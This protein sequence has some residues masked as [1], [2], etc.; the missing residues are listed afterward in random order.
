M[1][2]IVLVCGA[3]GYVGTRLTEFLLKK[4]F[5]VRALSHRVMPPEFEKFWFSEEFRNLER[6]F[7]IGDL[8][9][10]KTAKEMMKG[11]KWV[12]NL[13]ATVGGIGA[14]QRMR[15][16][17]LANATI[18]INLLQ[19]VDNALSGYFFAS[20]SC[21]YPESSKPLVEE[22]ASGVPLVRGY[23][24]EK[25]FSERVCQAF[26]EDYGIP[27][28][29]GRY[30][31]IYGP[32]D[33]RPGREHVT[34]AL[35]RKIVQAKL[36]GPGEVTIWGNGHQTR[37]FLYIDDCVEGTFRLMH[38]DCSQPVNLAHADSASVNQLVD[39]LEDIAGIDVERFYKLDAPVGC[40]NKIAD[41]SRC[42]RVLR[43]EPQVDLRTGLSRMYGD[44]YDA[45]LKTSV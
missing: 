31:T 40:Q 15:A 37:S 13:A 32:G 17:C 45:A 2:D 16:H 42:R 8:R 21:V 35:A 19:S 5:S 38:S 25:V 26:A 10:L 34:E 29:I 1:K 28:R 33:C 27:V 39:Y 12:Y 23:G 36:K 43:W 30:H 20:S 3:T 24:E 6:E 14:I 7:L 11:V 44:Y 41:I 22:D 9:H 4:G 18:N